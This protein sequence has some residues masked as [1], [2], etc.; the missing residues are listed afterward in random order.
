MSFGRVDDILARVE[1]AASSALQ[2]R[3]AEPYL[4]GREQRDPPPQGATAVRAVGVGYVQHIDMEALEQAACA[5]GAHFWLAVLPGSFM[6][7]ARE[8][9]WVSEGALDDDAVER[10]RDAFV[11]ET[12][13]NFEQDPRFGM[14]ALAE[15]ASRAL[16]PAVNDPGTAID[17]LGRL[18]RVLAQWHEPVDTAPRHEHLHVPPLRAA[19]LLEDAFQPIARDG[20]SLIEVQIRFQKALAA[21]IGIG[22]EVFGAS[23][24][25]MSAEALERARREL[26][27]PADIQRLE[28]LSGELTTAVQAANP[29]QRP[30]GL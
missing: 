26:T 7:P 30:A 17:I 25:Q 21:L 3:I 4:G 9:L 27:L 14:I 1:R 6:H 8:L 22:P 2:R 12:T 15:I 28:A 10:I 24:A 23:A 16:S 29:V 11:C 19:E 18:V 20:A 5:A 13:R